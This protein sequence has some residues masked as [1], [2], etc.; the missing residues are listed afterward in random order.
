[1]LGGRRLFQICADPDLPGAPI[2]GILSRMSGHEIVRSGL[3]L[4]T[5]LN[6]NTELKFIWELFYSFYSFFSSCKIHK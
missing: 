5:F 4:E 6:Q 1:M 2:P 3:V